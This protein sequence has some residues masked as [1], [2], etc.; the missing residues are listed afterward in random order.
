M[1]LLK[2][3]SLKL[4]S[5]FKKHNILF[6][7]LLHFSL[8]TLGPTSLLSVFVLKVT[9]NLIHKNELM[10]LQG[11][12][13]VF[14]IDW[15]YWLNLQTQRKDNATT[16]YN[17]AVLFIPVVCIQGKSLRLTPTRRTCLLLTKQEEFTSTN[18]NICQ[19]STFGGRIVHKYYDIVWLGMEWWCA[20]KKAIKSI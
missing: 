11:Y 4:L 7:T 2:V 17:Y 5:C 9:S 18:T 15:E 8:Q 6:Q 1:L 12:A 20:H 3:L 13:N 16:N 10:W 14:P 19:S